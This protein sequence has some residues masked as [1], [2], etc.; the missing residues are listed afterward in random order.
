MLAMK[1][2]HANDNGK[3]IFHPSRISWSYRYR[4]KVTLT[5]TKLDNNNK[6]FII[7][8]MNPGIK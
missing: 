5:Q 1:T 6:N 8:Q 2:T 3:K 7:N 4:G